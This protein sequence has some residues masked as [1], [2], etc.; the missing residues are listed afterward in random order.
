MKIAT[1][2]IIDMNQFQFQDGSIKW[3]VSSAVLYSINRFQFQDGSI[4][5]IA[6]LAININDE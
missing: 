1:I 4:K 3:K 6:Y 5:C 2:Q